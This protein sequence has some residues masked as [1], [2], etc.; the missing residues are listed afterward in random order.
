M[1][2]LNLCQLKISFDYQTYLTYFNC[3]AISL[4]KGH[5]KERRLD[6]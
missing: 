2:K 4:I 1:I 6:K 5:N 3:M